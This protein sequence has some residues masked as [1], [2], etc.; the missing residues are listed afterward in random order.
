MQK[1]RGIL[2]ISKIRKIFYYIQ[3]LHPFYI[4]TFFKPKITKLLEEI[5]IFEV[6][7]QD[8]TTHL[9][10]SPSIFVAQSSNQIAPAEIVET[11]SHPRERKTKSLKLD[12]AR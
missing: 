5:R 6:N 8:W 3:C 10:E 11:V 1:I 9:Q 12:S 7:S 2:I 4:E